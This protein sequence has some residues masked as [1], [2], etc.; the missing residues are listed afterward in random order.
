MVEVVR[1]EERLRPDVRRVP[2]ER[3]RIAKRIVTETKTVTVQVRRE[4]LVIER[5]PASPTGEDGADP[6]PDLA[7][8]VIELVLHEE[9]PEVTTRIVPVERV[10]VLK[11]AGTTDTT[12]QATLDREVVDITEDAP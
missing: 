2:V 10:R 3:V 8:P 12:V 6:P 7:V 4:E 5:Q 11:T 9:I 1:S